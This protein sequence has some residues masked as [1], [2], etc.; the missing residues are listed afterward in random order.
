MAALSTPALVLRHADYREYDR[1]VTLFTPL[2][3]RIDAVA[4]GCRRPKSPLVNAV[5]PFTSGD[6]QLF[7]RKD[8]YTIE[9]CQIHESFY[10]LRTDYDQLCH[11]VYWLK[12][13]EAAIMPDMPAEALFL[14]TLRALAHLH[15]SELPLALMTMAYEMH[16]MAQLG[17]APRMDAC[18]QCGKPINGDARFD[19]RLGGAVCLNC[20]S[21]APFISNGARRILMK[22]P[23]T[24][25]DQVTLLDGHPN[26]AEAARLYRTYINRRIHQEKFAPEIDTDS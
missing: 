8:R 1:M 20:P 11:G 21:N 9:Q 10:A 14:I 22:L 2:Y 24:R 15:H 4:R 13:L 23:R 16:F 25:Y 5:E 6:Y 18:V 17:F 12:L 3:G 7:S 19:A 26:W